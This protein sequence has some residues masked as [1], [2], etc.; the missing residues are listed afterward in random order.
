[1]P[2]T[3]I[4]C[5]LISLI[6][7]SHTALAQRAQTDTEHCAAALPS[8]AELTAQG[9]RIRHIRFAPGS[10]FDATKTGENNRL[11]GLVNRLHIKTKTAALRAQLLFAEGE[12]FSDRVL[13]E[14]ARNLRRL[15][16][17]REPVLT[18]ECYSPGFVDV[19]VSTR[20][21]WT[22]SPT[23]TF[24]RKGG[25]NATSFGVEDNNFLGLGK[26][27]EI[28]Q[29]KDRNRDARTLGYHDPNLGFGRWTLDAALSDNSDGHRADVRIERPFFALDSRWQALAAATDFDGEISRSVFGTEIDRY[30]QKTQRA[31]LGFGFSNGLVNR[32]TSRYFFGARFERQEFF[33]ITSST[34]A[35]P[36]DRTLAYPYVRIEGVQD[37]FD[38]T[39][40]QDQIGRTEDQEFGL[41]YAIELGQSLAAFGADRTQSLFSASVADG[42][43]IRKKERLFASAYAQSRFGARSENQ[44]MGAS[45]RYFYRQADNM[46]FYAAVSGDFGR[47]LDAESPLVLGGENGL[48]AYPFDYQYGDKRLLLTLEQRYYT[49]WKPFQLF[50]VGAAAFVDVGKV[51]G[52]SVVPAAP[53]GTLR[54]VGIGLRLG[55]L[56]AAR[57]NALHIDLAYPVDARTKDRG[58][59]FIVETRTSF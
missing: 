57:A 3:L 33:A 15:R 8:S 7:Y 17:L 53:L 19:R 16:Y 48:R 46:S 9:V 4:F 14:T 56:R 40:N 11:Y 59:Q 55:S 32:W 35:T 30:R 20:D 39:F 38:T 23:L 58:L 1:M 45:A 27:L 10:I 18:P 41:H 49:N 29:R 36:S 21:V 26:V 6:A 52:E 47:K 44:R 5:V 22:L 24:G 50:Q 25:Q 42:L 37:Q 13:Q 2:R 54:D 12:V 28:S 31:E 43:S 34:L 51:W